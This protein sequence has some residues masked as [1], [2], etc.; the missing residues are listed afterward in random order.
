VHRPG[1]CIAEIAVLEWVTTM[2]K[3]NLAEDLHL[4]VSGIDW[5][6]LCTISYARNR[7]SCNCARSP[8]LAAAIFCFNCR[9][10]LWFGPAAY[11]QWIRIHIFQ[12]KL[13]ANNQPLFY[14]ETNQI[15]DRRCSDII[16][17]CFHV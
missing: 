16:A 11:N 6:R 17:R 15:P 14:G 4:A 2:V 13:S 8:A 12:M 5:M 7:L 1:I 9:V 10:G 3:K